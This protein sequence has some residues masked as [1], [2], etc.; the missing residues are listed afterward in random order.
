MSSR[1]FVAHLEDARTLACP[2]MSVHV[3][4]RTARTRTDVHGHLPVPQTKPPRRQRRARSSVTRTTRNLTQIS[5]L[6]VEEAGGVLSG[7]PTLVRSGGKRNP[8]GMLPCTCTRD[9]S[10][11]AHAL[12]S[13]G[14]CTQERLHA[15]L[16][17]ARMRMSAAL[18]RVAQGCSLG[19]ACARSFPNAPHTLSLEYVGLFCSCINPP[20]F[21]R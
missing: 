21:S 7:Q 15:F 10:D 16:G 14:A 18:V 1:A 5:P 4:A 8:C 12:P 2:C 13:G 6:R 20:S 17:A 3:H 11:N 9:E 19:G